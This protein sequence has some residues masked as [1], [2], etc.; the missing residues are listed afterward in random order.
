M[1]MIEVPL[2]SWTEIAGLRKSKKF[3]KLA[4]EAV[5]LKRQE[6]ALSARRA[7]IGLELY[8]I[9]EEELDDTMKSVSYEGATITRKAGGKSSRFDKKKLMAMPIPC[10]NPKCKTDNHVTVDIIEACTKYGDRRPGVSI[11]LPGESEDE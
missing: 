11:K 2:P 3:K 6:K 8:D 4:D 1:P 10:A 9:L 5:E 7:E